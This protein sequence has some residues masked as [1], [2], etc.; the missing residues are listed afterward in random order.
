VENML[1]NLAS[2]CGTWHNGILKERHRSCCALMVFPSEVIGE[3][4]PVAGKDLQ[5]LTG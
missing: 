5:L 3:G 1:L 4:R 2:G